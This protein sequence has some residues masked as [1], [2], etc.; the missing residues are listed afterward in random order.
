V[1]DL[2]KQGNDLINYFISKYQS[3]Y[4]DKPIINKN[5][6]KWAA[7][8]LVDSFGNDNCIKAVDW[9]FYVKDSNHSWNWFTGNMEKLHIARIEK[10]RDDM[11]RKVSRQRARAWLNG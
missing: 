5:T 11:Q 10:E 1:S 2:I 7:R 6:A 3:V 9:Y 8:D 4:Q